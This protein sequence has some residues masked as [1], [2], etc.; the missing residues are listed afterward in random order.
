MSSS[1]PSAGS[2]LPTDPMQV[3]V[4]SGANGNAVS[5]LPSHN[6]TASDNDVP[7][8]SIEGILATDDGDEAPGAESGN[9]P[10]SGEVLY[11]AALTLMSNESL[12]EGETAAED[13][14][15]TNEAVGEDNDFEDE[16]R[17]G[18]IQ[19]GAE[20]EDEPYANRS[21]RQQPLAANETFAAH[22]QDPYLAIATYQTPRPDGSGDF[23]QVDDI[24][25]LAQDPATV[26]P[27]RWN[28]SPDPN[29]SKCPRAIRSKK[30]RPDIL[31]EYDSVLDYWFRRLAS[32]KIE[33]FRP[34]I[35][36]RRFHAQTHRY[37]AFH[38]SE[39][40]LANVD[41]NDT[42]WFYAY[43]K[44]IDQMNRRHNVAYA[45]QVSRTHWST[46]ELRALCVAINDFCRV[47]G[48]H[49]FGCRG[50]PMTD[51]QFQAIADAVNAVGGHSRNIDSVRGQINTAHPGKLSLLLEL[52]K[53]A[54]AMRRRIEEGETVS[55]DERHPQYAMDP[56]KFNMDWPVLKSKKGPA[57]N[58]SMAA[59]AIAAQHK[60]M[61]DIAQK[62]ARTDAATVSREQMSGEESQ[63]SS[64]R[65]VS[66]KRK[67]DL[68]SDA[69][70]SQKRQRLIADLLE[71]LSVDSDT[72]KERDENEEEDEDKGE[73][74]GGEEVI[75]GPER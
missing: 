41:P 17:V 58:E 32:D 25:E 37:E 68:E 65:T 52:R 27:L 11:Q 36:F 60:A 26:T 48:I 3:Q 23:I 16:E 40:K 50:A 62:K 6:R 9:S 49:C 4:E 10:S 28:I 24:L 73:G 15:K 18:E 56:A 43:N 47:H 69:E 19:N 59:V 72:E 64:P 46:D 71:E 29:E 42:T 14:E 54:N 45:K 22:P 13:D 51:A 67:Y 74:E 44:W 66:R 2:G 57:T 33:Y 7:I 53:A 70:E 35:I 21:V 34:V 5:T 12:S 30:G 38:A 39:R 63:L 75:Y 61:A 31:W 20:E 1:Q 8:M 55:H